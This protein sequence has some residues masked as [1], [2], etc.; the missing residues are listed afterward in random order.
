M[1][2]VPHCLPS[3]A[4]HANFVAAIGDADRFDGELQLADDFK[5]PM[6]RRGHSIYRHPPHVMANIAIRRRHILLELDDGGLAIA[7][8]RRHGSERMAGPDALDRDQVRPRTS[9]LGHYS[10]NIRWTDLADDF[11]RQIE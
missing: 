6:E 7:R 8:L 5:Q 2:R 9:A 11:L 4:S 1:D 10:L 3:N